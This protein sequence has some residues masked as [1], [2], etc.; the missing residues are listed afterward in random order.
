MEERTP[1]A[2]RRG[3]EVAV[4]VAVLVALAA[5]AVGIRVAGGTDAGSLPPFPQIVGTNC[6]TLTAGERGTAGDYLYAEHCLLY[7]YEACQAATLVYT[8]GGLDDTVTH[9][10]SV[11]PHGASCSVTDATIDAGPPHRTSRNDFQ[12]R[13]MEQQGGHW[14]CLAAARKATSRS[15]RL[16]VWRWRGRGALAVVSG[17]LVAAVVWNLAATVAWH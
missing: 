16:P 14:S 8:F 17:A 9:T 6:G 2:R 5:L 4:A 15:P 12:C 11:Q 1:P 10:V 3:R 13:G 7:A